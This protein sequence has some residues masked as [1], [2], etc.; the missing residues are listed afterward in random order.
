[1]NEPYSAHGVSR[2]TTNVR[3]TDNNN[4][5]EVG[6]ICMHWPAWAIPFGHEHFNI[7]W[8]LVVDR[9]CLDLVKRSFPELTVLGLHHARFNELSATDIVAF[10]GPF[11]GLH[12]TPPGFAGAVYFDFDFRLTAHWTKWVFRRELL[13]HVNCGGVSDHSCIFKVGLHRQ[14]SLSL[15]R[16]TDIYPRADLGAILSCTENGSTLRFPPRLPKLLVPRVYELKKGI[17]HFR[18]LFPTGVSNPVF[19]VPCVFSPSKW[20]SRSLTTQEM[21][22][23]KDVPVDLQRSL[24]RRDQ[25]RLLSLVGPPIKMYT[26]V[27]NCVGS[28]LSIVED[29]GGSVFPPLEHH[30]NPK[31]SVSSEA[32]PALPSNWRLNTKH[33][34]DEKAAKSDDAEVP[35][36]LWNNA[37]SRKLGRVLSDSELDALDIIR[38]W[39]INIWKRSIT[40]CFCTWLRCEDCHFKNFE[41]RF[42]STLKCTKIKCSRCHR[43]DKTMKNNN[44]VEAVIDEDNKKGIGYKWCNL[45]R[46][47][48]VKWLHI[49]RR[50][51]DT[52]R[53][54]EMI[55]NIAAGRDCIERAAGV[56][57]WDWA[58]GS[59]LFFWR[60]GMEFCKEIR[61]GAKIYIKRQLPKCR[62]KQSLPKE[63][64]IYLKVRKKVMKVRERQYIT[65]GNVVSLTS[66]FA[67]P[68]GEDDI[69]LVYNATSSGLNETVWAPWFS[70]PTVESHLRQVTDGTF[71]S[72]CDLGEMFLNFMLD[73]T[74]RPYAGVDLSDLFPE[75]VNNSDDKLWE[76]WS[77]MLMGFKSS[78]YSTTRD[79]RRVDPH[80]RGGHDNESNVF[81]W[82]DVK[83]NLPGK[84][85]YNPS[86]PWV[87]KVRKDGTLAADLYIYIDDLRNTGPTYEECWEGAHQV[88]SRLTWFG[89]QDAPRKRRDPSQT[90][91]AWAGSVIHTVNDLVTVLVSEE[92]WEKTKRWIE[93]LSDNVDNKEGLDHKELE[94]CRGFLIYVSRTYR[95]FIPYLRGIHKTIDGWR[96][97]R[98]EWGWK[99]IT[100]FLEDEEGRD[101]PNQ[102]P[103]KGFKVKAVPR[104]KNDIIALSSLVDFEAPPKVV[105]RKRRI[106]TVA[107]G[108]GDASGKGFGHAIEIEGIRY[109][110]FGQWSATLEEKHSNYKELN[111]L[112]NAVDLASKNSN[113]ADVE[114]FLFTDNFVS[115][116]AYY[117]GGSNR[118]RELDS[119]IFRLWK[120]QMSGGFTLH[121]YHVSGTRM[122]ASGIDGLSRGDKTE[123][124]SKGG[125]ILDYVPIHLS[126]DQRSDSLVRW[127]DSW[128]D[129]DYGKL[130]NMKPK[131]WFLK[132]M[133][134]GNFLWLVPPA[135]GEVAVEQLCSHI[136]GRPETMHIFVIPR[137]CTCHWRKQL[138]KAC[139]LILTIEPK[140]EFW[141]C[142]MFEPLL[143]GLR[144]PLLPNEYRFRPWQLRYTEFI[145]T[146]E[147]EMHG[148]QSTGD[149]VD[150]SVL[151]QLLIQARRIPTLPDGMA[152][153]L[154]QETTR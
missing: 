25:K 32:S 47:K 17:F 80:L 27:I 6:I 68:K 65:A 56:T 55:K 140:Y 63:K 39:S 1:M 132:V 89:L 137:L 107:Y 112:V 150:W 122:I 103:E 52:I 64:E 101:G 111:N 35:V 21:L 144:F 141:N 82:N 71:M 38:K 130:W 18:G 145:K 83:L 92:K 74:I 90:P 57:E 125:S 48:Y 116:C 40:R 123:G 77:R 66:F 113:L 11:S 36:H 49:Y 78:P 88:C 62:D 110:E 79:M 19:I 95:S 34:K 147:R 13:T 30:S 126:P 152:R 120:L 133:D 41:A 139:D 50:Q 100:N 26:A 118:S 8:V 60:W 146:F 70:L 124:I 58:K 138:T 37:L 23:T 142:D 114:L 108:F 143:I 99:V 31:A 136:H 81:R 131:D 44:L 97:G 119:L 151:Q 14:C 148:M 5:I 117:N 149:S 45:G 115:E 10:N 84:S 4:L 98:D 91:G 28:N 129:K 2:S 73:E 20:V 85:C 127:I 3:L 61:D 69:R 87:Y 9:S 42:T 94:R 53:K 22:H 121:V 105:R 51:G 54:L 128:W 12:I 46:K 29:E 24:G 75:E 7:L 15:E 109:A 135:A 96:P 67:V 106:G 43:Y 134:K 154:L 16:L 72:D 86:K 93:W 59:R 76:H 153:K 33:N 102:R 104:L